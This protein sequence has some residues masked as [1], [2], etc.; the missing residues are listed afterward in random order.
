MHLQRDI[1]EIVQVWIIV[2]KKNRNVTFFQN[3]ERRQRHWPHFNAFTH[4]HTHSLKST[5][6]GKRTEGRSR[7]QKT[8]F[9]ALTH[10]Q[11]HTLYLTSIL[12]HESFVCLFVEGCNSVW[13]Q[14]LYQLLFKTFRRIHLLYHSAKFNFVF[15]F[16]D[17]IGTNNF[18]LRHICDKT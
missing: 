9:P 10:T 1:A 5:I 11:T 14:G 12:T 2:L 16:N 18:Y 13:C 17:K 8:N 6:E 7:I 4:T 3:V 15:P